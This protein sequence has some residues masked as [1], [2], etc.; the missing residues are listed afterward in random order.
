MMK[1]GYSK[2]QPSCRGHNV[3]GGGGVMKCFTLS[4]VRGGG[5]KI[6]GFFFLFQFVIQNRRWFSGKAL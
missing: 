5:A 6:F 4:P 1:G 2:F 3:G